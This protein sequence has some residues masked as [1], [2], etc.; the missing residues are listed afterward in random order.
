MAQSSEGSVHPI[1]L[2]LGSIGLGVVML[3]GSAFLIQYVPI[4]LFVIGM[5]LGGLF[6]VGGLV[7]A[8]IYPFTFLIKPSLPIL[9]G[10][11]G[12]LMI[13]FHCRKC[14]QQFICKRSKR[15]AQFTCEICDHEQ[16]IELDEAVNPDTPAI[17]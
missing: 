15:G 7:G 8:V 10:K 12:E 2:I 16:T 5:I 4:R 11:R 1:L 17:E 6:I 9:Y 14:G 13:G 3:G